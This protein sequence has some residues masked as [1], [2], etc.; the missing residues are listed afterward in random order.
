MLHGDRSVATVEI[1]HLAGAD[2]GGADGK[3]RLAAIDE[4]KIDQLFERLL[5]RRGRVIAGTLGPKYIAIAGMGERIGPEEAG[6]AVGDRRP[7]GEL[8]VKSRE[9]AAEIPGRVLLHPFPEF[10][11]ARE[12]G[13]RLIA[14]DQA[15]I[16]RPDRGADD[17]VRLDAGFVERLI[18]AGLIGAERTAALQHQHDL[19]RQTVHLR[20]TSTNVLHPAHVS[21]SKAPALRLLRDILRFVTPI[22]VNVRSSRHRPA[23]RHR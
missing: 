20:T 21:L 11:Q 6:N 8:L 2:M 5:Q 1:A 16:D 13:L 9:N 19:P 14:G 10:L 3:P 23:T 22:Y 4:I 17:P 18:D 7:I 12:P 15:R